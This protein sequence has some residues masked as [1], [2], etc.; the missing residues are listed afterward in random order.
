MHLLA[1]MIFLYAEPGYSSSGGSSSSS[2]SNTT[3]PRDEDAEAAGGE[4]SG[5][6]KTLIK[7]VEGQGLALEQMTWQLTA[8]KTEFAKITEG[9]IVTLCVSLVFQCARHKFVVLINI[10]NRYQCW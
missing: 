10:F 5:L 4:V 1:L 2:T 8:F 9:I 6:L 3:T 7:K